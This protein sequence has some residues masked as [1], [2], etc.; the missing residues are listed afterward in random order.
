MDSRLLLNVS[1]LA[2][3]K[4]AQL[5]LG[6]SASGID[7]D[8]FV[9][10]CI[11]YMKRESQPTTSSSQRRRSTQHDADDD[12]G[13]EA[14]LDWSVLGAK[15]CIPHNS[16]PAVPG[17]L[18]GPLSVQKKIRA[19]TQRR[20]RSQKDTNAETRPESLTKDDI[21][22]GSDSA[23]STVCRKIKACLAQHCRQAQE[24]L[25]NNCDDDMSDEQV[26][27]EMRKHRITETG[28]P[29][30]FDFVI[31]PDDFGQTVENLFY[32]SFLIKE[33]DVGIAQDKDGLPTLCT[34]SLHSSVFSYHPY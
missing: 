11:A 25:Q 18:L 1:D 26:H 28:G 33:G 24:T 17:F 31:H 13:E 15:I 30:L 27:A 14:P 5:V 29:S 2:H 21:Q 4:S 10:K 20:V 34:S 12:E 3:K 19:A 32:V 16:R 8:D 23:V 9:S 6:D 7:V 22:T